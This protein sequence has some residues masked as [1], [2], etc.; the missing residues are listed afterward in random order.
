MDK[1]CVECGCVIDNDEYIVTADGEYVCEDCRENYFMCDDCGEWFH[2]DYAIFIN[3]YKVVCE[4]CSDDYVRCD[5][6]GEYHNY[7]DLQIVRGGDEV[8]EDCLDRYYVWCDECEE[9]VEEDDYNYDREMCYDCV[10]RIC[11]IKPYHYHKGERPRFYN[12]DGTVTREPKEDMY[13]GVE[14]EQMVRNGYSEE[15]A[16]ALAEILGDRAYFEDDCTVDFECILQ[17]HTFEALFNSEE[18]KEAFEYMS[19]N[20]YDDAEEAGLHVHVSR[21]AFGDTSEE[22]EENIAKL[23]VLHSKGFAYDTL[24]TLS[25]RTDYAARWAR[26]FGGSDYTKTDKIDYAKDYAGRRYNDHNVA[27]NCGNS[28]T[29]EFRLGAGTADYDKFIAWLHIIKMLVEKCKTISIEDADNFFVWFE[30]A[31][32]TVKQYMAMR[33]VVWEAPMKITTDNYKKIID[34]LCEKIN[35]NLDAQGLERLN[36]RTILAL[37]ANASTQERISLGFRG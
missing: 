5:V 14:L 7:E 13:G 29:V 33:G 18:I 17:P 3:D 23:I 9:Y 35:D 27:V 26:A 10:R 32:D 8:C 21:T 15:H 20:M 11:V 24:M 22:Q 28:A 25:R 30:D 34:R 12:S 2:N 31:D 36:E 37:I 4:A 6:C 19:E 1:I 16:Q